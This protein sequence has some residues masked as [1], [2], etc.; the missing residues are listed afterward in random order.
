MTRVVDDDGAQGERREKVLEAADGAA[1]TV[2]L[3]EVDRGYLLDQVQ[4]FP[5]DML[6][7]L[8]EADDPEEAERRAEEENVMSGLDGSTI[9]AFESICARGIE[10]KDLTS[11]HI[12]QM[13]GAFGLEV[14]FP[15]G[16]EIMEISMGDDG[17]V[18]DFHEPN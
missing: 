7:A 11:Q 3:V 4:K 13:V 16:A 12:E 17:G 1:L 5:D 9:D 6:E 2:E 10:H 8:T 14:L 18:T 15:I